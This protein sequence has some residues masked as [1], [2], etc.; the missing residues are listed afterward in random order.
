[1]KKNIVIIVSLLLNIILICYISSLR[2]NA[3]VNVNEF[4]IDE[5]KEKIVFAGDSITDG[6]NVNSYYQYTDKIIINSGIGGYKTTD[7]IRRFHNLIEQHQADKMFLLIGTNDLSAKVKNDTVIANIKKIIEMTKK[8]SPN[9]KIYYETIY[10][11]NKEVKSVG[12]RKNSDII[13]INEKMK[14]YC[15]DN[16]ITYIDIFTALIDDNGNLKKEYTPDVLHLNNTG[17]E[18]VT[19][20]LRPYVEE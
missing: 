7:I 20:L 2:S 3:H 10:P 8:E 11:V 13:Y 16:D 15:V 4:V 9:T 6:Y 12:N 18:E 19:R 1:M 17:Y 5:E 14:E